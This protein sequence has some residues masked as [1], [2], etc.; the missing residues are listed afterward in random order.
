MNS[1]LIMVVGMLLISCVTSFAPKI[2]IAHSNIIARKTSS[3]FTAIYS[4]NGPPELQSNDDE[5]EVTFWHQIFW[6]ILIDSFDCIDFSWEK[7]ESSSILS[8]SLHAEQGRQLSGTMRDK[9]K[10]ELQNNGADPN[11]S[12]G[13]I[14]GNP[15]LLISGIIAILVLLGGKGYFF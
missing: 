14:L 9:M 2:R 3:T 7:D 4:S 1:L 5:P 13:P 12:A 15:I 11:Y 10:R 6:H 8:K